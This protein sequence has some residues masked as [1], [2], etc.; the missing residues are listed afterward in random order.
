MKDSRTEDEGVRFE[1]ELVV[2]A[3]GLE[4][5]DMAPLSRYTPLS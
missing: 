2:H 1:G 3:L 5:S 4:G